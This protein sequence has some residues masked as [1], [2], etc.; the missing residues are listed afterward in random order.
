MR[1][2]TLPQACADALSAH[3]NPDLFKALCDP[4]RLSL[5]AQIATAGQPVTVGEAASGCGVHLSGVSRHLAMLRDAGA[6]VANRSGR[7]VSYTVNFRAL[8]ATLR[9][10]ADALEDCC[11]AQSRCQPPPPQEKMP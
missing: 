8:V 1:S 10:L 5:L 11:V 9:G 4:V 3:L 7:E 2:P 6:L